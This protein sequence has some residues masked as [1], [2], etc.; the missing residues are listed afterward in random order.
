MIWYFGFKTISGSNEQSK[1]EEKVADMMPPASNLKMVTTLSSQT[2]SPR[3]LDIPMQT[4]QD[5]DSTSL[6]L[7][8]LD[9]SISDIRNALICCIAI[10]EY[11]AEEYM[12]LPVDRDVENLKKFSDFLGY[13]FMEKSRKRYWTK[14]DIRSFLVDEVGDN[15]FYKKSGNPKHDCLVVCVTGHGQSHSVVP[16]DGELMNR[17]DIHRCISL[18]Y[19]RIREIPRIFIFDACAGGRERE[20]TVSSGHG[21][22]DEIPIPIP[23]P[24]EDMSNEL[25]HDPNGQNEQRSDTIITVQHEADGAM[26]STQVISKNGTLDALKIQQQWTT[27]TPNPDYKLAVINSANIGFQ[28]KMRGDEVGS[29]FIY[30]FT[31]KIMESIK[32][33]DR[34]N[35]GELTDEI[36]EILH[37]RGKQLPECIFYNGTRNLRLEIKKE[38][39]RQI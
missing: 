15:L 10:G 29:F 37:E 31:K 6:G 8:S 20:F 36:Q 4:F 17:T 23:I 12:N 28:A 3:T 35:L 13:Q 38:R 5:T 9:E 7:S 2:T 19:P 39:I 16:S 11:D 30:L 22:R 14:T 1:T 26:M 18:K 27:S 32:A 33:H 34:R 24:E 21:S 25:D